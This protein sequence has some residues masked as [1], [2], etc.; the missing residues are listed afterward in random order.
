MKRRDFV[1]TSGVTASVAALSVQPFNI[2]QARNLSE[3]VLGLGKF[4]YRV[5]KKWGTLDPS[6][7]PVKNCHEMVMDKKGRLIMITDEVKNNILI[8][9]KNNRVVSNPGGTAPKYRKGKLEMMVQDTPVFNHCH[10]VC[11]DEDKN[12]YVYQ[13][14]AN[15]TYPIKLE[16]A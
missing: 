11:V 13:S 16:R 14:N 7:T 5:H 9:D 6:K 15:K 1:K 3:E 4:K 8:Y 10:D 12:L 2:I